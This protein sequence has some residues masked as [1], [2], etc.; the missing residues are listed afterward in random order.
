MSDLKKNFKTYNINI[1]KKLRVSISVKKRITY[2]AFVGTKWKHIAKIYFFELK[3]SGIEIISKEIN[4][5]KIEVFN[6]EGLEFLN[7]KVL[8]NSIDLILTDPPY[9]ISKESGFEKLL[10]KKIKTKLEKKYAFKSVFEWDL[11]FNLEKLEKFIKQF[12]LKL[13]FGGTLIIF[14]DLWKITILKSILIKNNFK[15]IRFIEWIKTNPVPV[16]SHI[17]YLTNAREIALVAIKGR[18]PCFNSY[19]DKGIY[20][21]P[22]E[23]KNR[24][25]PNQK[26]LKLFESL[27]LKHSKKKDLIL[28]CF[29]GSGTTAFACKNLKRNFIGCELKE[30]YVKGI[31]NFLGH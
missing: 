30:N 23:Q 26:N 10:N 14:F 17:N 18:K 25:H 8:D 4:V 6:M 24:T 2:W 16:N 22:I 21:F 12:Y 5:D 9:I 11:D 29:L 15:Q 19:Y 20:E 1:I 31:K 28:D 7:K 27:I 3:N 13:K